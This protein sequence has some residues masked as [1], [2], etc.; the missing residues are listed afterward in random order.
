[1]QYYCIFA[2]KPNDFPSNRRFPVNIVLVCIDRVRAVLSVKNTT[3]VLFQH[4]NRIF[5][6]VP[7]IKM[8]VSQ[9]ILNDL[10][11]VNYLIVHICQN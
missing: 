2:K 8:Q 7:K 5:T 11:Y 9:L 3:N 6:F 4:Q 10:R 1:M